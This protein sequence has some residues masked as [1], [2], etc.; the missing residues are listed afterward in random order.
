MLVFLN[1]FIQQLCQNNSFIF[2]PSYLDD[3]KHDKDET[4][5]VEIHQ[6]FSTDFNS[7]ALF[8]F[9]SSITLQIYKKC[10]LYVLDLDLAYSRIDVFACSMSG[11]CLT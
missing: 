9:S 1:L 4:A 10:V 3:E 8:A 11:K 5:V 6:Y 2:G 7:S